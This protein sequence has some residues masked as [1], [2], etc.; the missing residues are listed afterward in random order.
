[1]SGDGALIGSYG[2]DRVDYN[3]ASNRGSYT[4]F[5]TDA[6]QNYDVCAI[7][8]LSD[9]LTVAHA[10]SGTGFIFVQTTTLTGILVDANFSCIVVCPAT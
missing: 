2:V 1:M 6:N 7:T 3:P 10:R 5:F 9:G 8:A 4:A